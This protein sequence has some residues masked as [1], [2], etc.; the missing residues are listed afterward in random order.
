MENPNKKLLIVVMMFMIPGL[1][2][3]LIGPFK[4]FGDSIKPGIGDL[5]NGLVSMTLLILTPVVVLI[6]KKRSGE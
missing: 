4:E 1:L 6:V 5:L 3:A 2:V